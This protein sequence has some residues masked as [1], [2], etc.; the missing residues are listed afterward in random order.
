MDALYRWLYG[1]PPGVQPAAFPSAAKPP[2]IPDP[3]PMPDLGDPAVVAA[4]QRVMDLARARSGRAST[5]LDGGGAAS[6]QDYAG[7]TLGTG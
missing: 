6:G 5:S 1:P 3:T 7:K 4:Q 2:P